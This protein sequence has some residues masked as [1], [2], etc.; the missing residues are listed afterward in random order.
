MFGDGYFDKLGVWILVL[1]FFFSEELLKEL[2][3]VDGSF[4]KSL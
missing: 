4:G 1:K 2:N 3:R